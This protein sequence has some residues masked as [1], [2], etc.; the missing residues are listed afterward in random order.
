MS[1]TTTTI[2]EDNERTSET[3]VRH[4]SHETQ[5]L[6]SLHEQGSAYSVTTLMGVKL[7]LV[8]SRPQ[9]LPPSSQ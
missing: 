8:T 6:R 3:L 7:S 5:S 2:I 1:L 4:V 9:G